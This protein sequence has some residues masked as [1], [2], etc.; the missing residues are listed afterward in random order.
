[1]ADVP[2]SAITAAAGIFRSTLIRRLGGSR[3]RLD[4]CVQTPALGTGGLLRGSL[5]PFWTTYDA[6]VVPA[7]LKRLDAAPTP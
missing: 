6:E 1:V 2:L 3:A 5:P 7:T 4:G